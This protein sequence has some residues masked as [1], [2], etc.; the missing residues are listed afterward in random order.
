MKLI[1]FS[2]RHRHREKELNNFLKTR[3]YGDFFLINFGWPLRYVL[4]K[5]LL[6]LNIGRAI[7]CDG[8]PNIKDISKGINFW[9]RGISLNIP[10]NLKNLNN[11][12]VTINNSLFQEKKVFQIYPMNIKKTQIQDDLKIIYVF[13]LYN[14]F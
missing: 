3:R 9:M 12:F 6:F 13:I 8:R 10:S 1:F 2:F 7:S 4:G 11:N 14:Y 5:L